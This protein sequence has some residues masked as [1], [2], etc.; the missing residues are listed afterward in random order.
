MVN[1]LIRSPSY[2]WPDGHR[3]A[4]VFSADVDAESPFIWSNRGK[5]VKTLGELEQRRFGPRRGV[6]RL[7]D[8][9]AEFDVKGSFYIPGIVMET[10]P[11]ITPALLETDHEVALHGFYHEHMQTLDDEKFIE[12]MARS[13]AVYHAQGGKSPVGF[14]SPAWE[15]GP[16]QI[17]LLKSVGVA[18]DSSLMGWDHPYT[19]DG[20]IE[21]PVQW[22]VDDAIYFRYF[23]GGRDSSPPANPMQVLESWI[24]EFDA[25]R[26][27]GGLFMITVHPW[28]S[29]RPQRI[30]MLRRLFTHISAK[31]DVWWTTTREIANWHAASSNAQ[32]FN[33]RADVVD[34]DI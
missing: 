4:V 24:M 11:W 5:A 25:V 15:L 22:L 13:L 30:E 6:A 28:M 3:C 19:I 7:V 16:H 17:E 33:V 9:L 31:K 26:D 12:V 23:G 8:L 10:Y 20:L 27:C 1:E 2:V 32:Y 14:R 21:V 34:T 29:G 18:Y